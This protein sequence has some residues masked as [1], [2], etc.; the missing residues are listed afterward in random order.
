MALLVVSSYNRSYQ[1]Q[2]YH[3]IFYFSSI[4]QS[5]GKT[6]VKMVYCCLK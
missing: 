3:E 5:I 2:H 1:Q 4:T 6:T